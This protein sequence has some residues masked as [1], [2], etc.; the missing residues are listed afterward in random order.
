V[1]QASGGLSR[2]QRMLLISAFL[3]LGLASG[4]FAQSDSIQCSYTWDYGGRTWSFDYDFPR[5]AYELQSALTRTLD[6]T[7][8]HMYVGDPRDDII[9][10][11]FVAGIEEM[12]IGLNVWE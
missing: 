11:D 7:S 6:Y 10:A 3:V 4:S 5:A 1:I 8:Y 9:L 2:A 12:A